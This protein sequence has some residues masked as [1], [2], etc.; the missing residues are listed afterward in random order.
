MKLTIIGTGYVGLVTGACFADLG[1]EVICSD[2]DEKKIEVLNNGGVP[3][4]EPGLEELVKKNREKGRLSFTTDIKMA[5]ES[6]D[7]I[8][9]CV[10][11]PPRDDGSADLTGIE[12]VSR[13]VAEN[14]NSY[15]LIV[16]KS[17]VPV[18]TGEW[19]KNT[20]ETFKKNGAEF[21]VASNPEFLR[22]GSAIE[23]FMQPD[24]VVVGVES[25]KAEE[26]LKE[27]YGPLD[28]KI[29]VTNIKGAEIIKHASNS[30]LATKISFINAVSNI[31]DKVG[32]DVHAVAEG[33][34]M[35]ARINKHFLKA[36]IGFGGSCFPKDLKA[37]IHISETMG[38]SFDMLKEV[39]KIN[40][41]QKDMGVGKISE[42][43]WNL[44]EKVIGVWGLS[45]KPNTDDIRCAPSIDIIKKLIAAGARIKAFDPVA[46]ENAK[47]ELGDKIEYCRD[48]YEAAEGADCIVL[49]T[50]WNEFKEIDLKRVKDIM[51]QPTIL[52]GRNIYDPQRVKGMGFK[53]AGIGRRAE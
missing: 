45:F 15:K 6:S 49:M 19:V 18:E 52:D 9:V 51:N 2:N 11:T 22:E 27:L 47:K 43:L 37:F 44:P 32:A 21:D 50:E 34:G 41:Q 31:C 35:D 33:I 1:N 38:Y 24:R 40:E 28:T 8:F 14:M 36:G 5:V 7:V 30:F 53:Y 3:I 46:M 13:V 42:M 29:V 39:E 12:K 48:A 20:I 23:D 16:E 26:L 25:K 17:T 10:G 4:Y